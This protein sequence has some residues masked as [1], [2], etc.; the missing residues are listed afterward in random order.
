MIVGCLGDITFQV[1]D[2]AIR[3]LDKF[4]WSGKAI[5][6]TQQ[7]HN[8]HALTEYSGMDA[9]NIS[10]NVYL[11]NDLLAGLNSNVLNELVKIW[12]YE[13]KG[14]TLP[15]TIGTH[16]YGK[17]RWLITEHNFAAEQ[18]DGTGELKAGTV[19]LSLIEYL[20]G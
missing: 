1:D 19:S 20:R 9:D 5:V 2:E 18:F 10:F 16:A 4:K 11:S 13:R 15:L 14:T 8:Y 12:D 7:R 3:T 6:G 17:Y